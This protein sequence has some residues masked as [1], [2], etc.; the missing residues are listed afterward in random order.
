[1]GS[2]LP[3]LG[4]AAGVAAAPGGVP[5]RLGGSSTRAA[6]MQSTAASSSADRI[7]ALDAREADADPPVDLDRRG[8]GSG[9]VAC[10]PAAKDSRLGGAPSARSDRRAGFPRA[11]AEAAPLDLEAPAS[12]AGADATTPPA[13]GLAAVELLAL[14]A[15]VLPGAPLVRGVTAA[16]LPDLAAAGASVPL[17]AGAARSALGEAISSVGAT[18]LDREGAIAP[19]P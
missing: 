17:D 4:A 19:A 16:G 15:P 6:A 14:G 1:M 10:L 12:V 2:F 13:R 7:A 18:P 8:G 3:S 5:G 11:V 9:C